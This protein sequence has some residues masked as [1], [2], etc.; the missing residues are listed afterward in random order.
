MSFGSWLKTH[1]EE[2][3]LGGG[4]IVVTIALY[5]RSRSKSSSSSSSSAPSASG[6]VPTPVAYPTSTGST[7]GTDVASGMESQILG[8]QS[9]L[10]ALK[11]QPSASSAGGTTTAPP[12]GSQPS[13]PQTSTGFGL[14][15]FDGTSYVDLGTLG[16]DKFYGYNVGNSGAPIYYL[17]PGGQLTTN[18]NSQ[19]LASLPAGTKVL[20]DTQA[21]ISANPT[22][23][24]RLP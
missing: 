5:M 6:A 8:L 16:P 17:T 23:M 1:R 4:G 10:L 22:T 24:P 13:N 11:A 20:T 2:A 7:T 3:L 21:P 9:A 15:Q 18:D 14:T 19:M 12:T